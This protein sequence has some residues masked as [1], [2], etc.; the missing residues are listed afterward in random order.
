MKGTYRNSVMNS[1]GIE[2]GE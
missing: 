2:K 1:M